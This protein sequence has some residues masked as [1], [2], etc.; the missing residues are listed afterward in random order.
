MANRVRPTLSLSESQP[1]HELLFDFPSPLGY[2][3]TRQQ[4]LPPRLIP[5]EV[6]D[7]AL[8]LPGVFPASASAL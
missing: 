7:V 4:K 6:N 3:E 8:A 2:K 5:G 1:T